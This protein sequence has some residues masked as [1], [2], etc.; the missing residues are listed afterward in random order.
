MPAIFS[1]QYFPVVFAAFIIILFVREFVAYKKV[2]ALKYITTPLVTFTIIL[3]CLLAINVH[4]FY[5]Y[6]F[7]IILGLLCSLIAD[8]LL[9]IEEISLFLQGLIYFLVA[10]LFYVAAFSIGYSFAGWNIILALVLL[11]GA[12]L[13]YRAI[14][15]ARGKHYVPALVYIIILSSM[16]FFA[17]TSLNNGI[18]PR[19]ILLAIGAILFV[20]SDMVLGYN[21]FISTIPHSTVV[22]WSLYAPAQMF[23]AISCFY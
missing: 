4:G 8:T 6:S 17:V 9:M 10:H 2:L 3:M 20:L 19:G 16:L 22:T 21:T 18:H 15:K 7:M 14:W 23:I 13:Y 1:V 11:A 12:L 5:F